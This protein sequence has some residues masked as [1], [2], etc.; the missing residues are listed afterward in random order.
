MFQ[1]VHERYTINEVVERN[2]LSNI[3]HPD[4]TFFKPFEKE[5]TVRDG[6]RV[7]LFCLKVLFYLSYWKILP[8]SLI[9]VSCEN[10]LKNL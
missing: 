8:K 4:N 2:F 10:V 1:N 3:Q 5:A 9:K 7:C 6:K